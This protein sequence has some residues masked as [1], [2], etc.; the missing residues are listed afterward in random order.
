MGHP[1]R[2]IT[3][4]PMLIDR[5]FTDLEHYETD[6]LELFRVVFQKVNCGY[7]LL[8]HPLT[9]SI[10]PDITPY[11]TVLLSGT[12]G[13]IDMESVTLIGKA[14]RYAEDLYRLRDI[15]VYKKWGKAAREDFQLIDLSIIERA[16]EVEEMGK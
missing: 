16:L 13:T 2:C 12:A 6:V 15:P 5:G 4:N 9:G 10:R 14:I 11:K 7:R 8:T 3:N 1:F